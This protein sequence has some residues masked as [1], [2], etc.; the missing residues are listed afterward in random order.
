MVRPGHL[1]T[2]VDPQMSQPLAD[3]SASS[4]GKPD[5]WEG[6]GEAG[7]VRGLKHGLWGIFKTGQVEAR[8]FYRQHW[9]HLEMK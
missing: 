4:E 1:A 2:C 3:Y 7:W 9:K 5:S 8:T 6:L